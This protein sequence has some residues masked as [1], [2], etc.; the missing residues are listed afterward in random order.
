MNKTENSCYSWQSVFALGYTKSYQCCGRHLDSIS[1]VYS[2]FY[3]KGRGEEKKKKILRANQLKKSLQLPKIQL[4][5]LWNKELTSLHLFFLSHT[6]ATFL[7]YL[8]TYIAAWPP[9]P[10]SLGNLSQHATAPSAHAFGVSL[11]CKL[12]KWGIPVLFQHLPALETQHCG[13]YSTARL[14]YAAKA[15]A[16]TSNVNVQEDLMARVEFVQ[17]PTSEWKVLAYRQV[18]S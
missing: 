9:Q 17:C 8:T 16:M 6:H 14:C 1:H 12:H 13:L 2:L 7:P 18:F 3:M 10:Y 4:H 15:P 5:Y 11:K